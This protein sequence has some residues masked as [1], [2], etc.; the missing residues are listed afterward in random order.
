[1]R[2]VPSRRPFLAPTRSTA[3]VAILVILTVVASGLF[4][5]RRPKPPQPHLQ[6]AAEN[7]CDDA[8]VPVPA[9]AKAPASAALPDVQA[10]IMPGTAGTVAVAGASVVIGSKAVKR[11]TGIGITVLAANQV[12]KLDS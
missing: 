5:F 3:V 4:G 9:A 10:T 8:S 1:M 6:P 7:I 2:R 11:P 12:P